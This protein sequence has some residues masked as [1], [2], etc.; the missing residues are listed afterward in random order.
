MQ[1]AQVFLLEDAVFI[2]PK[3]VARL[4]PIFFVLRFS[5]FRFFS[6]FPLPLGHFYILSTIYI[7]V[8]FHGGLNF[9]CFLVRLYRAIDTFNP[10]LSHHV[11]TMGLLLL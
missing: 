1:S 3:P 10:I 7:T 4:K 5:A 6:R 2:Q 9:W 8:R 11:V